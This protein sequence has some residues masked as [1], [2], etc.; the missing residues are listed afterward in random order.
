[1]YFMLFEDY[2]FK[3]NELHYL[4]LNMEYEIKTK[5]SKGF[6]LGNM[7]FKQNTSITKSEFESLSQLFS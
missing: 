6:S 1:M 4:G 2:P 3:G 7:K 5:C